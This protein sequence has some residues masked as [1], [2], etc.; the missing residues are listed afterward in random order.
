MSV[1]WLVFVFGVISKVM[2]NIEFVT[3]VRERDNDMKKIVSEQKR[4]YTRISWAFN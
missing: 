1:C 3:R 4:L 2:Y